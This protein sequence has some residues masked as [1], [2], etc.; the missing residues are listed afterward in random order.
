MNEIIQTLVWGLIFLSVITI[1]LTW[2]IIVLEAKIKFLF[3]KV[4]EID[5][6]QQIKEEG[7]DV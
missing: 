6:K 1:V 4:V 2:W 3:N 5:A 7:S